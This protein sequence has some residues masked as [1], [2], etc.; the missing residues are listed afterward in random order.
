MIARFRRPLPFALLA[1]LFAVPLAAEQLVVGA[2]DFHARKGQGHYFDPNGWVEGQFTGGGDGCLVAFVAL[3][4]DA[5]VTSVLFQLYDNRTEN[6][7][8]DLKRKRRGNSI[9]AEEITGVG[10]SGASGGVLQLTS[11]PVGGPHLVQDAYTYFLSTDG[12]C[13]AGANHRIYAVRINYQLAIFSDGFESGDMSAWG[14]GPQTIF[15]TWASG[16]DFQN[17]FNWPWT[18]DTQ[19][20]A[21]WIE[22][23]VAG[24]APPCA[25]ARLELP[26]GATVVGMLA[27]LWD[28]RG[29]R[30]ATVELRRSVMA[31]STASALLASASTTGSSGWEL[32]SDFTIANAVIDNDTYW[33]WIDLC[34]TGGNTIEAAQIGVQSVQVLYSLP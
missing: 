7:R 3:P 17:Q 26:H 16:I 29:D 2:A 33:Y 13:P 12:G 30:T 15:S 25:T 28:V 10:T 22:N 23:S 18:I 31:T 11:M 24:S 27:N 5:L 14:T 20:A 19:L 6:F 21:F 34:M 9:P 4:H 1:A 32:E 8:V